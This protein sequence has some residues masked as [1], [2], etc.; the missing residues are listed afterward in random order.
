MKMKFIYILFISI[1]FPVWLQSQ[2]FTNST[3]G[4]IP[5]GLPNGD[6]GAEVCFPVTVTGVGNINY[7]NGLSQVCITIAHGYVSDLS[8]W[9]QSPDGTKIPLT[10]E[11]G[12]DGINYTATCFNM[13]APNEI[14][15]ALPTSAPFT[16]LWNPDGHLGWFNNGQ[17]ANGTWNL[18]VQDLYNQDAG[19]VTSYSITFSNTPAQAPVT[20]CNGNQPAAN[21]CQF[22]TPICNLNGYCGN[23]S[24]AYSANVWPELVTAFCGS[25]ENNSFIS[26]VASATT[27]S[28]NVLVTNSL[29]A[30]GIQMMVYSGGCGSGAV[31]SFGCTNQI[32][33]SASPTVF[34]ATGLTVGNTYYLMIDGF[35]GDV[36]DYSIT[37]NSGVNVLNISPAAPSICS[38]TNVTL[39]AS[40]GNGT[41][42]WSPATNLSTTVGPIVNA[43]PSSTITYTVTSGAIGSLNCPLTKQVT[44]T[45]LPLPPTPAVTVT[46]QPTCAVPTGTITVSSPLGAQYTYSL[47]YTTYQANPV[48][49][50]V[51]VGSYNV[52]VKNTA[53]GCVSI[54]T[55]VTVNPPP[56]PPVAPT[57]TV[58]TQP[59]CSVPTG[60]ITIT[61][62]VGAGL[63]Y[64][65]NGTTYQTGLVF[66]GVA[67]GTYN[68]TVRNTA[69]NCTST[70]TI[71]VVNAAPG[72][73][74]APTAT[75]TS[76]PTC[77]V[78][79]GTITITAPTG[80]N[81][82]YSIDGITYQAGL[83][84]T[85]LASGSYN[86]TVK[87]TLTNCT[88]AATILV[89]NAAPTPPA[90][91]T[92]SVTV[93]PTCVV[94]FGTIVITAPTGATLEYS[95]NGTTYQAGTTFT[96]LVSATYN[97]TVR[98]TTTGCVSSA[99][100]LTVNAPPGAPAAPTVSVTVQPTCS[101]NTGTI[102]V[103][104][105]VGP[106]LVYSIN[107]TIYQ[108]GL[109]FSAVAPGTYNVTV[110][111][112]VS[113]CV[114]NA[115]PVTVNAALSVPSAPT[116]TVTSQ[117]TCAVPT[118]TIT[119]TAPTG[120]SLQYS[121]DG[122][123][124]QA[125][126][127]FAGLSPG[128]YNVTVKNTVSGCVSTTTVLVVNAVP[129]PPAAPTA[130]V[131]IQPTCITPTGTIVITAPTGANLEYSING[132]TYQPGTSFT[133]LAPATYNVTVRNTTTNCVSSIT[134]LTV[135]PV[136]GAPA[137]PTASVTTQPTCTT[138]TGTITVTAPIGANLVYSINGTTFQAGLVFAGLS[139]G[140]YTV[141]VKDNV[142]GC[143]SAGPSLT[144]NA[145][146]GIPAAPTA[147]ATAQPTCAVPT[148]T[149]TVSA[150]LGAGL[151]YSI[152]GTTYQ[153]GLVFTGLT[154]ATYNVTVRN[155][156]NGCVSNATA[157][158]INA[159][160]TPPASPTVSVSTQP[161]CSVATGTI[162]ITA[163][164]GAGLEY[165][166]NGVT[167][168]PGLAFAGVAPGN[169]NVTV[170]NTVSGCVSTGS[171]VTVNNIPPPLAAPTASV[172][173]QPNCLINTGTII[174]TV[175]V[176]ATIEYSLN[177]APFQ[178]LPN[179][180]GLT[181]GA[182][183]IIA[184][185]TATNCVSPATNLTVNNVPPKSA[186]PVVLSPVNY[187]INDIATA[188]SAN[189]NTLLWYT[190]PAGGIPAILPPTPSTAV[191][192]STTYY[193]TQTNLPN[194]ESNRAAIVVN[195]NPLPTADA[196]PDKQIAAGSSVTL[197]GSASGSNI[198]YIWT[199][200]LVTNTLTPV[201][202][203]LVETIYTL[204]V[205][206]D[207]GCNASD[208][209]TVKV[210]K[211]LVIPNIFSPNGDGTNDKWILK[212]LEQYPNCGVEIFNRYGQQIFKST[213]Y[214]KPWDGTYNG[215]PLPV[216]TYYYIINLGI[217][218]LDVLKGSITIIR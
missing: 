162:T 73:P 185:N 120:A 13:T 188:L 152:N 217:T 65:I 177:G 206:S 24:S 171:P 127:V 26:F 165:S 183:S 213:G 34:T 45:V 187:C 114:S 62:P 195:V 198:T 117:P 108:A 201:V 116:A 161:S 103:T 32:F 104:A 51:G 166:I 172:T 125:G 209:V 28:L 6:P 81:L 23:T 163:P 210:I 1:F 137:Q 97:V 90:A 146:T 176:G 123:T 43:N 87:N 208:N 93:Q 86:V 18:C 207:K 199:P 70:A 155:T 122:I 92:A 15:L 142:S 124:Y 94:P 83:V 154:P 197:S 85:G 54:A 174:I 186:N 7:T 77:A 129:V 76:Q 173:I 31:T 131:T 78:P 196:G 170:R 180:S 37:V 39:T 178:A 212:N 79:T 71:L 55:L 96:N 128:S 215:K 95:V 80:A 145:I 211:E 204:T 16:G 205:T 99:T 119:I 36:C 149:V 218:N 61:A 42:S 136:P 191:A 168:Q 60:T 182:Y 75:V 46:A 156:A 184:R 200:N 35:A 29:N 38:G 141:T 164:T 89:V 12:G 59:T 111:D 25:I 105:P 53:N 49:T 167:Y 190:Q 192:G 20:G 143:S 107:G 133:G 130:T 63:E 9:L 106:N 47:N 135:N 56:V 50:G 194:C 126:L 189:G 153:P 115:T 179:Y 10:V 202:S 91:P 4:L 40:G 158:T 84:F 147:S 110:K 203:P 21:Q 22:S 44:V 138:P 157:V 66:T 112:N 57:A 58:T 113:G 144:V 102:T 41:Y 68:V 140:N 121:I 52:T 101:V 74:A 160:P 72:A 5:D 48:F 82:Q 118:G 2:T 27:V 11:N 109:V 216:G 19:S 150:P 139:P 8:V 98:N 30:Q 69:T 151:E 88:S 64:S 181:P 132:V 193:V 134:V 33:P 214:T 67:A 100:I 148:G 159:V 175:P 3:G 14:A 169:Y 17:N